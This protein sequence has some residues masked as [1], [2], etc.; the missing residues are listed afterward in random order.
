MKRHRVIGTGIVVIVALL[1]AERRVFT[2]LP[3]SD[4]GETAVL[5]GAGDIANCDMIGGA[6][7]T[8]LL[9]DKIEGTIFTTGDHAYQS[10]SSKEFEKCYGPTWGRHKERTR[11]AI[12]NHDMVADRAKT[13]FE[14]FGENAGPAGLGYY[15]YDLGAWHII[16]LNS[17]AP[18]K[19]NSAQMKWLQEDLAAHPVDCTLAYWHIARFS[20]GAHGSDPL[21]DDVWKTLYQAG[22]DVVLSSH[23][24]DYERFAP[25]TDK[26]KPDPERGIREFVVGTGGG[27]VYEFKGGK[28]ANSEVRDNTTYGVLKLTLKPGNY[29]WEFIP[30]AGKTFTDAGTGTCSPKK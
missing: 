14:Y 23:D 21:M 20:S 5:V 27:G 11:P 15:S 16:S 19:N 25:Q 18:A 17:A 13:Y 26:G 10:G 29:D 3:P 30:M 28:A 9:L 8:A 24:H 1:A 6:R 22:A 12:G 7:A 2:Q 4:P